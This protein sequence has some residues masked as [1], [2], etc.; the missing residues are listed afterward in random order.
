MSA[1]TV[2]HHP[3][4][5][6]FDCAEPRRQARFWAQV[7]GYVPQS[8]PPGFASWPDYAL[9]I[10]I[11]ASGLDDVAAIVD[12]TGV[13][14]RL[15]FL[16]VPERKS[17]KNRVHLDINVPA[18]DGTTPEQRQSIV[19]AKATSLVNAGATFV[20]ERSDQISWWVTLLDP[21]GNEFCLQ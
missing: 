7:L 9:S 8:P 21:E 12:P 19:R 15:L 17:A 18:P 14:P 1:E 11:P 20:A 2:I 13:A 16:A 5:V 10:G 3:F 6:T 4:Q